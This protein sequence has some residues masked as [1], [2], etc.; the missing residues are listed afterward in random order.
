MSADARGGGRRRLRAHDPGRRP[1]GR[2]SPGWPGGRGP[3]CPTGE[4]IEA[5][6]ATGATLAVF[7][8]VAHVERAGAPTAGRRHG[9]RAGHAGRDRPPGR[10]G[11][12]SSW[13]PRRSGGM[14]DDV[15]PTGIDG[16]T[17]L[18][19]GPALAGAGDRLSHVYD[20]GYTTRF[21]ARDGGRPCLRCCRPVDLVGVRR[22]RGLRRRGTPRPSA[23]P[24]SSSARPATS[25]GSARQ[26]SGQERLRAVELAGPLPPADRRHPASA[27]PPDG[28]SACWRRATRGSS[29]SPGCWPSASVATRVRIHPAPSSVSLAWAAAGLQLG[30]RRGR[31]GPRPAPARPR[32]HAAAGAEGGRAHGAGQPARGARQGAAGPRVAARVASSSPAGSAST[33]SRWSTPTST[34]WPRGSSTRCRSCCSS[35]PDEPGRRTVDLVGPRRGPSSP[36][37]TA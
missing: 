12:T 15:R 18:L 22:G 33:T 4:T 9:L 13:W 2:A 17:V 24:T 37:A 25:P 19:V 7:L 34:G 1:V 21:R 28:G 20:P 16:T 31:L 3:R 8:S 29:A 32:S 26:P 36:T 35:L 27:G 10:R 14:A 23:R 5:F 30:R 6:A 11:P